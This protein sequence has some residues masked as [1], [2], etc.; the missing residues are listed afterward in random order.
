M[1]ILITG[2]TGLVGKA[3]FQGLEQGGHSVAVLT[4]NKKTAHVPSY[5]WNVEEGV[6][7][8]AAIEYADII[9]HL[10]GENIS[11]KMWSKVQKKIIIDSRVKTTE[12]LFNALQN[13]KKKLKAF[14][15]ASAIGYYGTYNSDRLLKEED[16]PGSDFLAET[17]VKWEAAVK[18]INSLGIPVS[19]LRMGVVMSLKGGVLP[20]MLTPIKLG[21]GSAIGNGKQ[22]VPWIALSDLAAMFLFVINKDK[23]E[24]GAGMHIYNA[25][26]PHHINNKTLMKTLAKSQKK[27]FFMPALPAFLLKIIYGE[28]ASIL[29]YGTRVSSE[30]IRK[31]G[32]KF[33][34]N[35]IPDLFL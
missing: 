31:D 18:K 34:I 35:S 2:G 7:D 1:N 5:Y 4:R 33:E 6:L 24:H 28:M 23:E 20:K 14:I 17:V 25:V 16:R 8:Q 9:I 15:S 22:W 30:K 13:K 12:L 26:A 10:A 29:L 32:F 21:M 3:I 11:N 27:P 19:I